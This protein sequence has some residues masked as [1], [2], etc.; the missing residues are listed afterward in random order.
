M[1]LCYISENIIN[2]ICYYR[3][4]GNVVLKKTVPDT[5][6]QWSGEVVCISPSAGLGIADIMPF[7]S[8]QPL[9]VD[10]ITPYSVKRHETFHLNVIV[11]NYLNYSLPVCIT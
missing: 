6:T 5:I 8:F 1:F 10:V 9:F 3:R 11:F 4:N 7:T 2:Y